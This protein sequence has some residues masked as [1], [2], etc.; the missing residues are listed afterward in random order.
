M[1]TQGRVPCGGAVRSVLSEV[2]RIELPDA[3]IALLMAQGLHSGTFHFFA[4]GDSHLELLATGPAWSRLVAMQHGAAG[5]EIVVSPGTSATLPPECLGEPKEP[6]RLLLREP[7]GEF[8]RVP[9]RPRPQMAPEVLAQ[10]LP[11]AVREHLRRERAA[12]H[13]P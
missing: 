2:G 12:R 9:L 10:C 5:D 7:P 8:A 4:V 13:R 1:A 3:R 11:K 6:G